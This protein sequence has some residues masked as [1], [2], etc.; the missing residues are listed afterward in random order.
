MM[1]DLFS[2]LSA[3]LSFLFVLSLYDI[4]KTK[5]LIVFKQVPHDVDVGV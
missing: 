3:V 1:W 5:L 2:P 4:I